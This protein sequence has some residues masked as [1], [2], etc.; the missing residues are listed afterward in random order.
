MTT[1]ALTDHFDD[2]KV[3]LD[4]PCRLDP[5][6]RLMAVVMPSADE[7]HAWSHFSAGHLSNA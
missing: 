7:R 4:E 2:E 5:N 3:Q 6:A 1:V